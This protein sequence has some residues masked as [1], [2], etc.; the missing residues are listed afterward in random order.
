MNAA[1]PTYADVS[2]TSP[3]CT[4][5]G[6]TQTC[7]IPIAAPAGADT[8]GLGFYDGPNGTGNLLGS[9]TGSTTVTLGQPFTVTIPI[10]AVVASVAFAVTPNTLQGPATGTATLTLIA[11]DA[12]GNAITGTAPYSAPIAVTNNDT[13]GAIALSATTFS[14]PADSIRHTGHSAAPSKPFR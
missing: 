3:F 10:S 2:A 1:A 12:D 7:T 11:K 14:K 13:T 5:A 8:I 6:T 4:L 9:G